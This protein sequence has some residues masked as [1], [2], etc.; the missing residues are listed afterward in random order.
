[1]NYWYV[2]TLSKTSKPQ[3]LLYIGAAKINDIFTFKDL[4]KNPT[5]EI[6]QSYQI[7][8]LSKYERLMDA[9]NAV[10]AAVRTLNDH[11]IPPLNFTNYQ[12]RNRMII[13]DQTGVQYRSQVECARTHGIN[14][15]QLSKHL[16]REPGFRSIKGLTFSYM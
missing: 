2:Y 12:R 9:K 3:E 8:V 1:M 6:D 16:S 10:G 15:G 14:Q 13:C 4:L 11:R 5:F 7:N